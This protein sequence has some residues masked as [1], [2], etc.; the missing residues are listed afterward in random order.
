MIRIYLLLSVCIL[1]SSCAAVEEATEKEPQPAPDEVTGEVA[2][3]TEDYPEWYQPETEAV[4]E[5][6]LI[7][8]FSR[9]PGSD[10]EWAK[11]N[12][13]I[14]A[15]ANLRFWI[16]SQVEQARTAVADEDEQASERA[17][18]MLIRNAVNNLD[19][20]NLEFRNESVEDADGILHVYVRAE[21]A[22]DELLAEL[23]RELTG[24]GYTDTW[25]RMTEVEPLRSWQEIL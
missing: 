15:E 6:G 10:I 3:G 12:A 13:E 14:Q 21:T 19:F 22:P 16:D 25:N 2:E 24:Y 17:F 23:N 18:I 20:S 7:T 1:L 4:I 5:D 9:S 11:Q 8:S